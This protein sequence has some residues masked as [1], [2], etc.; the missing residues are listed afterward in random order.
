MKKKIL[1]LLIVFSFIVVGS[2][3]FVSSSFNILN[4]K[5]GVFKSADGAN[6]TSGNFAV[7][8]LD[9]NVNLTID[10]SGMAH[11]TAKNNHDL[12]YAQ[13]YYSACQRLFQ[14]ELQATV[15]AGNLSNFVGNSGLQSDYTLR[16][17]GLSRDAYKLENDLKFNHSKEFQYIVW[18][19]KGVDAYINNTGSASAHFG[20]KLLGVNPFKWTVFDSL[21]WQEYMSWSLAT[22]STNVL[23]SDLF[24]NSLGFANYSQIWPYYPYYTENVTMIPGSGTVNNFN[25]TDQGISPSYL[26]NQNFFQS[27][28]TGISGKL[29]KNLTSLIKYS[30][31]NI[32]D[33]YNLPGS[34][35]TG[36]PVGSN[37]WVVAS[38]NSSDGSPMMAN[39]PHLP[40]LAPSLWI[41]FQL[42]DPSFNVTGWGL[43][44]LPGVLIGHTRNTSFGLTTPE[45]N[46]A[47]DYVE[48]LHGNSYLYNNSYI[49]MQVCSFTQAG[50]TYSVY[51]TNNG[52]L[53]GREGNIGISM[54]WDAQSPSTDLI[55][56]IMLDQ[57]TNY[58]QMLNA[59]KYWGPAPPQNFALVSLHHAGYITAGGYPLIRETLPDGKAVKVVGSVSL[60]NGSNPK[61]GES[62][63]VPFNYLPQKVNPQRGYM[64]APNQPTVGKNYPYPFVGSY[65]ATGG[66]AETIDHYLQNHSKMHISNMMSLQSNVTDYWA[67]Q[68]NPLLL[69]ALS[70]YG[71]MNS[72][73]KEAYDLLSS[74]NY[75]FYQNMKNPTV[76]QYVTAAF[77]NLTF[78]KVLQEKGIYKY[79][80]SVYINTAIYMARNDPS[81][82]WFNGSFNKTMEK[83]FKMAVAFMDSKLGAASNWDWGHI[84]SVEIA[85][86]TG[87]S[88]LGIGPIPIWGGRHTVSVGSVPR[89]LEYP[90]PCVSIGSSLRTIARPGSSSFYG[91]FPGGPS[92]NILS[93]WFDNQVPKW[94]NHEYYPMQGLPVEV[95]ITYEP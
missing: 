45:G 2:M 39:D 11:I 86:L 75:S 55:A 89:L 80:P 18:Y 79:T 51:M 92:E 22:G 25:L 42:K 24:V 3:S 1:V 69:K 95:R 34:H 62:G 93:Y 57:S 66:R 76:Y 54:N 20:F 65:W 7:P 49:P 8:G 78:D 77:Y 52:P 26:W 59:L 56:E 53:I 9:H 67:T 84:H 90:L 16:L 44:G 35:L 91:V 81:S 72:S 23:Q 27:W 68:F 47:N 48:F 61:Y 63:Y 64:F 43:A 60:L 36:S 29:L 5:T 83:A 40:L 41:E 94:I 12:F 14:M 85:S 15:A 50:H 6:F 87:I 70:Q 13:G 31:N 58:S 33:P 32:S 74:W 88:D 46:S 19:T 38:N 30:C 10:S 37:S 82:S 28:A 17:V 21:V 71:L 4:P 73:E